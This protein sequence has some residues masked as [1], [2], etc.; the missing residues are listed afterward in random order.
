MYKQDRFTE[1]FGNAVPALQ[2]SGVEARYPTAILDD[3]QRQLAEGHLYLAEQAVNS[4]RRRGVA[5]DDPEEALADAH[6]GVCDAARRF[7]P[8]V[9]AEFERYAP[10]RIRG[11][12]VDN[13]RIRHKLGGPT[14][15]QPTVGWTDAF[16]GSHGTRC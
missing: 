15:S 7:D 4:L 11:M 12:V 3:E 8:A 5:I 1:Y 10:A 16:P 2:E 6:E 13:M 9:G 14:R